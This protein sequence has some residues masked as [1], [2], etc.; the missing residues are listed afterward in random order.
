LKIFSQKNLAK[1]WILAQNTASL[2]MRKMDR[3]IG[4]KE[5]Q[6]K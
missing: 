5:T 1:K 3:D 2:R 4:L 6:W